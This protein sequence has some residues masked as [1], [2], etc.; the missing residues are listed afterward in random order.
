MSSPLILFDP[1]PRTP[2]MVY[3]QPTADALAAMGRVVTHFGSRAPA[4]LVDEVLPEVSVIVG[5]TAMPVDRLGRAPNLRAII[6]VKGNW[7]PNIAY[8]EAQAMGVYVLSAAPAMA[9]AVAEACVGFAIALAR[10]TLAADRAFRDGTEAYGIAGNRDSYSLF[11]AEIGLVG[12]GN[13]GRSLV[14]LLQPFRPRIRVYD[15]WVSPGYLALHGAESATL[16]QVLTGS[17]FLFVLAGVTTENEGFLDRARLSQI[18]ADA[19]VVLASRAEV[20]DFDALLELGEAG[21]FRL[22]VDVFPE[23]PVPADAP[24]RGLKN[25]LFSSHRAGG[26][27]DSYARI[28]EMM[29]DDI[30]QILA[31]H[32]PLRLQRAEPRQAA[33]MRSR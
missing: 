4:S 30:G 23:E 3:D 25:V 14:P 26:M 8:A 12:F 17:R 13:L 29:L 20:A 22:A 9:P 18:P 11:G 21:R 7:E 16:D 1:H 24:M 10:R 27:W 15:P 31:G 33:A 6:N 28:R 19:S 2:E 5:Q 32:P